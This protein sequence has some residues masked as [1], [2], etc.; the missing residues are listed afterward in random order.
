MNLSGNFIR[1]VSERVHTLIECYL[2]GSC[3]IS[4]I[5]F[6]HLSYTTASAAAALASRR[7]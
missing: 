4:G 6:Y 3:E 5:A 1:L 2:D 7:R